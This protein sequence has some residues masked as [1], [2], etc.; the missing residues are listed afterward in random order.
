[1]SVIAPAANNAWPRNTVY[2]GTV[3]LAVTDRAIAR[4]HAE[5][6]RLFRPR[7]VAPTIATVALSYKCAPSLD[8]IVFASMMLS[9]D[10]QDST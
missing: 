5:T 9:V 3:S 8:S 2:C 4:G 1:M 6:G 10:V 7:T